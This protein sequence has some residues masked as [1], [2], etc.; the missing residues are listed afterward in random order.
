MVWYKYSAGRKKPLVWESQPQRSIRLF[1]HAGWP[2]R[3]F[4]C[5]KRSRPMKCTSQWHE[6]GY[7]GYGCGIIPTRW[8][9]VVGTGAVISHVRASTVDD[10]GIVR[11]RQSIG[12][13]GSPRPTRMLRLRVEWATTIEYLAATFRPFQHQTNNQQWRLLLWLSDLLLSSALLD[14]LWM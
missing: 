12:H 6:M 4:D 9:V 14:A 8:D 3:I 5:N 1:T 11:I 2:H 10:N 13:A 7:S